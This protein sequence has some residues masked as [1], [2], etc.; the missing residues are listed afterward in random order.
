M[1]YYCLPIFEPI[2]ESCLD[3]RGNKEMPNCSSGTIALE[4]GAYKAG[5]RK[6]DACRVSDGKA[7]RRTK[8]LLARTRVKPEVVSNKES[9]LELWDTKDAGSATQSRSKSVSVA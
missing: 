6:E 8:C 4:N 3:V 7:G 9:E 5:C 2:T 1:L